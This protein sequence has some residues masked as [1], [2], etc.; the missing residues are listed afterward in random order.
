MGIVNITVNV[1]DNVGVTS[2]S[3]SVDGTSIGSSSTAPFSISWNTSS[4]A[5]GV[6]T[7]DAK[8]TDAAGNWSTSSITISKN[9]TVFYEPSTSPGTFS[10]HTPSVESQGFEA[11]CVSF[12]VGFAARSI[13]QYYKTNATAFSYASNLFSPEFLYNQTK[14]SAECNSGSSFLTVLDFMKNNGVCT[15]Q[16]MPYSYSNGCSLL[17]SAAQSSE[18]LNY[19]IASYSGTYVNDIVG[20]KSLLLSNHP[21][22]V[23][24]YPDNNFSNATTDFVWRAYSG[25]PYGGHALAIVGYNDEKNA[26]LVMNSWGTSW[27]DNGYSWIDYQFLAQCSVGEYCYSMTL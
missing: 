13:E 25:T 16:T 22:M 18:A 23:G 4:L 26:F 20:I 27:G 21:V 2:V 7:L 9:T 19:K 3:Y 24:V 8:A 12:A 6:H 15:W 11:S 17:P 10:L 5:T 14:V 1:T